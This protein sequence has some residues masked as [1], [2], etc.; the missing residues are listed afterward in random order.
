MLLVLLLLLL[1]M[2]MKL[3]VGRLLKN[4]RLDRGCFYHG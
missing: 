3:L 4:K 1:L 2:M